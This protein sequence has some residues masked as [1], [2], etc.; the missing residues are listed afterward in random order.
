MEEIYRPTFFVSG[1]QTGADSIPFGVFEE[2]H[3]QLKVC[4]ATFT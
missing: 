1:G 3:I 4:S 2:L